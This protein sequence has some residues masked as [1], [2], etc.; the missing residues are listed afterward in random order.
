MRYD[1]PAASWA[2]LRS[3]DLLSSRPWV[4]IANEADQYLA[5]SNMDKVK[6]N[7]AGHT[8]Y[9]GFPQLSGQ[10]GT[11]NLGPFT[12]GLLFMQYL[13]SGDDVISG[14]Y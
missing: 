4:K 14:T 6:I 3:Q 5:M 13:E 12:S 2:H 7:A 10:R 1:S 11:H 9:V 8:F